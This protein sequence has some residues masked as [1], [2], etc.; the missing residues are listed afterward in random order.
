VYESDEINGYPVIVSNQLSSNDALFGDFSQFVMGMWSGLDLT[1]D[2]YAGATSGNVRIIAL[3]D[4]DFAV[5]Q[6]G[7]F[8]YGT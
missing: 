1:V 5:K 6:P 2:P 3:Q 8:C 7:A 4:V